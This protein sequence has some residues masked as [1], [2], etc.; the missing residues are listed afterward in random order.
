MT[1]E[2]LIQKIEQATKNRV[3]ELDLSFNQLSELPL[4]ITTMNR[5]NVA[6]A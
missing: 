2:E 4:E 5:H 6:G 1:K 3:T